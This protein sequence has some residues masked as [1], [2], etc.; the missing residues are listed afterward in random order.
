M[1]SEIRLKILVTGLC[2]KS[3]PQHASVRSLLNCELLQRHITQKT[4]ININHSIKSLTS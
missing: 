4:G 3:V 1:I 2:D